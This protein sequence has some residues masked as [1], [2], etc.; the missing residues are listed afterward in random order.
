MAD[1]DALTFA[2]GRQQLVDELFASLRRS[3]RLA[4]GRHPDDGWYTALVN[5]VRFTFREQYRAEFEDDLPSAAILNQTLE[6]VQAALKQTEPDTEDLKGQADRIAEALA[7]AV[8]NGVT[9]TSALSSQTPMTKTWVTMEDTSVRPAHRSVHLASVPVGEPFDVGGVP[10]SRPGDLSAPVELWINCRC[11]LSVAPAAQTAAGILADTT[12]GGTMEDDIEVPF[13]GVLAPEGVPTRDGRRFAVGSMR[14]IDPPIPLLW[15][16]FTGEGHD[17]SVIVGN[18]TEIWRD[19]ETNLIHNRGRMLHTPEA[20]EV[21]NLMAEGALRG[22]SVDVYDATVQVQDLAGNEIDIDDV[23]AGLIDDDV[24]FLQTLTDG[25]IAG[26]TLVAFPAFREA[27]QMLGTEPVEGT[28]EGELAAA[29]TDLIP[30]DVAAQEIEPGF[31][32]AFTEEFAIS[33]KPWDGSSSRFTPQEWYRSTLVHLSDDKE[34]KSDHKL[35]IRE[36]N[37]D[38]SRAGVHAAASRLN[39][40]DAPAEKISK[41]KAS[42]RTA[43]KTLGED[44]PEAIA[45]AAQEGEE[46]EAQAAFEAALNDIAERFIDVAPGRT[47]DGPG[48]LTHPV[49]TDRLRD[50]WVRGAGAAKIGWGT[51]GDF[52][53]CRTLLAPYVKPQYLSGYCANRHYD[54]LGFWPGQHHSGETVAAS[55]ADVEQAEP[56]TITPTR[57]VLTASAG[58]FT[59]PAEWF[60]DPGLVEPSPV[61]VTDEGRIFGHLAAWGTCHIGIQGTCVTPPHSA[62]D[63]DQFLTGVRSTTDG[64][65][66]VGQITLGTGHADVK[67]KAG[68]AMAHYDNTGVAVADVFAGEDAHGIW[69][70]GALRPGLPEEKVLELRAAAL[71][72]DWRIVRGNLELVAALAVNVPGFPI[73]RPSLAASA[74]TQ[75][76]LVAAGVVER[77]EF[78]VDDIETIVQRVLDRDREARLA[79]EELAA[80]AAD[81]ARLELDTV[82]QMSG[83]K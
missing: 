44:P 12:T 82:A 39:Q 41:A 24:E 72:G 9:E 8:A 51:P 45:A 3:V 55:G 42:L 63:Y 22:V 4:L 15:Q 59:P 76:S 30:L 1:E 47:E 57:D 16:K 6:S 13:Y 35:P 34:N 68:P 5:R 21:I 83:R 69:I 79:R 52:N 33:E 46:M 50:Y 29:A 20:E 74:G 2:T 36:P 10:M 60:A 23:M 38:L 43:Y 66:P 78:T 65:I 48:W 71:S 28:L 25:E 49:D 70:A 54:A 37:G 62:M 19:E 58:L 40:V 56:W 81:R 26:A 61:V 67:L 77:R 11:I 7:V 14:W 64:D 75:I 32:G 17:D 31:E 80:I 73:P 27:Y 53:R 18:I